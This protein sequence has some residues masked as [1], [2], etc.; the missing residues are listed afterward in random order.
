M[1]SDL[2]GSLRDSARSVPDDYVPWKRFAGVYP[3][4]SRFVRAGIERLHD[5]TAF[6]G[7]RHFDDADLIERYYERSRGAD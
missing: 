3:L 4:S 1:R 6:V 5:A 7:R 2:W